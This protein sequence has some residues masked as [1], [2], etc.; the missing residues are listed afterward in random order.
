MIICLGALPPVGNRKPSFP[1]RNSPP[2]GAASDSVL[3]LP[4]PPQGGSHFISICRLRNSFPVFGGFFQQPREG[5]DCRVRDMLFSPD[6]A[7]PQGP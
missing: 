7:R 6:A 1:S 2:T 4:T 3:T 5:R